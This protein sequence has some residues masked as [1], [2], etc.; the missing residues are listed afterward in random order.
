MVD[1]LWQTWEA[2]QQWGELVAVNIV[3]T[4]ET[5]QRW[6]ERVAV[7][8]AEAVGEWQISCLGRRKESPAGFAVAVCSD[9]E[10]TSE[11]KAAGESAHPEARTAKPECRASVCAGRVRTRRW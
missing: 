8:I 3:E 5:A 6:S 2:A 1:G 4:A 9:Q 11:E 10:E 7:G